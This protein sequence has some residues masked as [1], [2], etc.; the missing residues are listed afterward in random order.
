M[1]SNYDGRSES[2][3]AQILAF[4]SRN[5]GVHLRQIKREL[6]LAMGVSQYHLYELEKEGKII[7]HKGN[8]K[9]TFYPTSIF[10]DGELQIM[11]VLSQETD[12]DILL[13]LMQNPNATQKELSKYAG[14]SP[15]SINWHMQRL[16]DSGL[17]EAKRDG[18]NVKYFVRIN[19]AKIIS[20]LRDYHPTVWQKWADRLTNLVLQ[21]EG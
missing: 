17:V 10:G 8:F 2:K 1:L 9:K 15:G 5:P 7:P 11:D 21:I 20:L 6:S 12:R 16:S 4:I 3:R 19:H 14:I 18:S 13:F